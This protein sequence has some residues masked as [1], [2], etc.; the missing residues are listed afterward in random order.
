MSNFDVLA[1]Y[2]DAPVVLVHNK[3]VSDDMLYHYGVVVNGYLKF[4]EPETLVS[5]PMDVLYKN[6]GYS[7]VECERPS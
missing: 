7:I 1:E 6:T 3:D 4:V 5:I 2:P